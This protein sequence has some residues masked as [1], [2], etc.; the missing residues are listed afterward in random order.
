[1]GV[2]G[3]RF[4]TILM[5]AVSCSLIKRLI[6]FLYSFFSLTELKSDLTAVICKESA[7]CGAIISVFMW[8]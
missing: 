2:T 6:G 3:V 4:F 7:S 5:K 1:M 8:A